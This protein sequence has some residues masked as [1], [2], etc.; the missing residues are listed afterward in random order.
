MSSGKCRCQETPVALPAEPRMTD[1]ELAPTAV[2]SNQ[3]MLVD[4]SS[5]LLWFYR[6]AVLD[7][8]TGSLTMVPMS[9]MGDCVSPGWAADGSIV[10][11]AIGLTGTLWRYRR[12][13]IGEK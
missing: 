10:C 13:P 7:L 12:E 9:A 11:Q 1:L 2:N 4:A 3:R 8:R 6:P 5:P